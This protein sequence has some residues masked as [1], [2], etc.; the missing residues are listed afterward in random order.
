MMTVFTL[1]ALA[2]QR[3]A[4]PGGPGGGQGGG[5]RFGQGGF[6]G[7]GGR[8]QGRGGRQ[9][10]VATMRVST[11]DAIVK[12]TPQQ[13]TKV[14][15]LQDKYN[16]DTA[17]LRS[18]RQ[19]G[20]RPDQATF[21]KMRD[22]NDRATKDIEAV[23]TADQK[24]KLA[25]ARTEMRLYRLAGIPTG[26]YGQIKLT[27]DQKNKLD[28]IQKSLTPGQPGGNR[29]GQ[30]GGGNPQAMMASFQAARDK[31]AAVLTPAQKAQIEKYRKDHPDEGR[32]GFGGGGFG[33]GG[34]RGGGGFGGPRPGRP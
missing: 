5:Q 23:L 11:L 3:P 7:G 10:S 15:Q 33:G 2:Q 30:P 16:K 26:M 22:L 18:Q 12:L 29:Q 17:V 14:T 21:Q 28:A 9:M 4:Q 25:T 27:A 32:G 1:T 24:K 13:K 19:P 6:G 20:Q 34:G 8:G 31:A